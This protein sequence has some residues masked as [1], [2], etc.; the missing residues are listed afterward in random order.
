[1]GDLAGFPIIRKRGA[2]NL[3]GNWRFVGTYTAESGEW[4]TAQSGTDSNLNGDSTGDRTII[5]PA[6]DPKLGSDVKALKNS[7]GATVAYVATNPH[8]RYVKACARALANAA[9]NTI[10]MPA[11][12]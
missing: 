11:L 12:N 8:A 3:I 5:N 9:R 1:M 2:K 6:G 4:V 7:S 10:L